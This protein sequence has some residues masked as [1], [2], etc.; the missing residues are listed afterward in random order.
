MDDKTYV[1][2]ARLLRF[3]RSHDVPCLFWP[4]LASCHYSKKTEEWYNSRDIK[5]IPKSLNPPHC[6]Q[7]HPIEKFWGIGKG[8]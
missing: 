2:Q 3:Y 7:F 8:Y 5:F 1:L 6:P 4:D